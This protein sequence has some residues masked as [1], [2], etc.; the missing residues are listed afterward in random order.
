MCL[1]D[2]E[3]LNTVGLERFSFS[4]ANPGDESKTY[5]FKISVFD[6]EIYFRLC[7]VYCFQNLV[8]LELPIKHTLSLALV[9]IKNTLQLMFLKVVLHLVLIVK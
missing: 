8:G 4:V 1:I 5:C 2:P 3:T 9:A 6:W 7:E